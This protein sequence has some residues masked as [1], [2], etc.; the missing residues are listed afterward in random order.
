[1]ELIRFVKWAGR[2]F[3]PPIPPPS[4]LLR[5][6]VPPD[7]ADKWSLL[8]VCVSDAKFFSEPDSLGH[9]RRIEEKKKFLRSLVSKII[10]SSPLDDAL[11]EYHPQP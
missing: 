10:Q 9:V 4:Q 1:M 7:V 8:G 6:E 11:G 2:D 5:I 3:K